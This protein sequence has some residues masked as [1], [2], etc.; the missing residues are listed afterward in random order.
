MNLPR[1]LAH[2]EGQITGKNLDSYKSADSKTPKLT[3]SSSK[4]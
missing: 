2:A 4:D 1:N 3:Q